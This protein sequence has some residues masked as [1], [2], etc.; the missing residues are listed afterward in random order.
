MGDPEARDLYISIR[1]DYGS[2]NRWMTSAQ[3][4]PHQRGRTRASSG[5]PN[6]KVVLRGYM[7]F[8]AASWISFLDGLR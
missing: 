8:D 3:H 5:L 7:L 2:F 6:G 1:F 4:R